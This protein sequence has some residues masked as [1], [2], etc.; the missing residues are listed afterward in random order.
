M[1]RPVPT[2]LHTPQAFNLA[3]LGLLFLLGIFL[4]IAIPTATH[5]EQIANRPSIQIEA[6]SPNVVDSDRLKS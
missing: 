6:S 4:T 5:R 1:K 3:T 2:F